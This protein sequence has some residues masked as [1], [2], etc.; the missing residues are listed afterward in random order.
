VAAVTAH[1]PI[2]A[3]VAEYYSR[4]FAEHGADHRGVDWS[5]RESQEARFEVLL[6]GVDWSRRPSL[7]DYGCGYGALGGYV[8]R[9]GA[10]CRYVGHDIVAGMIET[11]RLANA[12]RDDRSFTT[13]APE[14]AGAA[15][16]GFD[17]VMASGIFN[18]RLDARPAAWEAYVWDTVVRLGSLAGR[19]L[20]FNM[21]PPV[22]APELARPHLHHADP[23]GV[24]ERCETLL[25]GR[26]TVRENYGL[27][28]FTVVVELDRP[29]AG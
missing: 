27:W 1:G 14:L 18:V 4:A 23:R 29:G 2:E 25:G 15:A 11:A 22:S 6:D 3:A 5:S 28:E 26:V 12:G 21:L 16:G 9:I 13:L 24:A 8:D 20:A 17:E 19:R 10:E 7:L